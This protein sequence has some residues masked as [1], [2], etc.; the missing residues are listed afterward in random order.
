MYNTYILFNFFYIKRD[1]Y[2][3]VFVEKNCIFDIGLFLNLSSLYNFKIG[4]DLTCVDFYYKI[5][6]FKLNINLLSIFYKKKLF[7]N[8]SLKE[9]NETVGSLSYIFSSFCWAEREAWDMF[10]VFF[11]NNNNLR[12]ILTDYG[13]K[14][15][16][17]RKDS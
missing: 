10:G 15:Y 17:L 7:I 11:L 1:F 16:P 5:C 8:T 13:F 2:N 12:R 6:R 14:G 3:N 4:V 9:K